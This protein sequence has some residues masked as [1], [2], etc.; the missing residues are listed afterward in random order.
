MKIAMELT[1]EGDPF[2][3]SGRVRSIAK[4]CLELDADENRPPLAGKKR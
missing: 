4:Q 1:D 2:E 3:P